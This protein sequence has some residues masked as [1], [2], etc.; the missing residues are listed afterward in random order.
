VVEG[1]E[2]KIQADFL[3]EMGVDVIQ[4]YYFSKPI[5]APQ[6]IEYIQKYQPYLG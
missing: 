1:V 5:P 3:K 2:N 6:V 4:G